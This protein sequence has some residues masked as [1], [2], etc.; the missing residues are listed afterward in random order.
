MRVYFVLL[1]TL[2]SAACASPVAEPAATAEP[3]TGPSPAAGCYTV[4]LGGPVAP[5]VSLPGVVELLEEP[6]PGFVEPGRLAVREPG[7][8]QPRAPI[9][10]WIPRGEDSIELT[11]GG[12]FTGYTFDLHP[13][14]PR[15]WQGE[16]VYW[17][18]MGVLPTPPLLPLRLIPRSC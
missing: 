18:D 5:D 1:A 14:S 16:G 11:L 2:Y 13:A 8:G 12:G 9:S 6:A 7:V 3:N 15:G 4:S 10:W 17:A